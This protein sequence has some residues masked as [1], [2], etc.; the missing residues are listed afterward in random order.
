MPGAAVRRVIAERLRRGWSIRTAAQAGQVSN[1]SWGDMEAGVRP[2]TPKMQR[3]VAQ[4]F[5]WDA[6]WP[7]NGGPTTMGVAERVAM[8]EEQ[9]AH[10]SELVERGCE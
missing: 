7:Y 1:T 8:L 9:V 4:A 3:A 6:G 5:G 10:L 2:I